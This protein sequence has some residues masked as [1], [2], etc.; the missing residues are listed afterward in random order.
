[1]ASFSD[2]LRAAK[3]LPPIDLTT[4]NDFRVRK[5]RVQAAV[6]G[7]DVDALPD[8][9][10]GKLVR[11]T[12]VGDPTEYAEWAFSLNSDAEVDTAVAATDAGASA[13]VGSPLYGT[14]SREVLIPAK[15]AS[16][17]TIYFSREGS[18]A[19]TIHMELASD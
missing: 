13:K 18:A 10:A 14:Q 19:L 8:A 9:W 2:L 7:H 15:G 4:A 3:I 5:F 6:T 17:Q 1:M 16:T 11:L 12:C